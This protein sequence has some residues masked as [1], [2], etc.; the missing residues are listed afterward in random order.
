MNDIFLVKRNPTSPSK[1]IS[2]NTPNH[3]HHQSGHLLLV[4]DVPVHLPGHL[5]HLQG[6]PLLPALPQEEP[7]HLPGQR[8][9]CL[10]TRGRHRRGQRHVSGFFCHVSLSDPIS[11]QR[12]FIQTPLLLISW[13]L[14]QYLPKCVYAT[15]LLRLTWCHLCILKAHWPNGASLT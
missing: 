11:L 13:Y 8:P 6:L 14:S 9:M 5:H 15:R 12:P 4:L 7:L 2:G 1:V 3:G 10:H